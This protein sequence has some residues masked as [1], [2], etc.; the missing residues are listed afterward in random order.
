MA[1]APGNEV[2]KKIPQH[3]M[4]ITGAGGEMHL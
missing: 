3:R 1:Q 2:L 4:N